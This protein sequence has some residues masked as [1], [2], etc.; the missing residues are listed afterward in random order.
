MHKLCG[1]MGEWRRWILHLTSKFLARITEIE[2]AIVRAFGAGS[3]RGR[4][5][6]WSDRKCCARWVVCVE[7]AE[8]CSWLRLSRKRHC[9]EGRTGAGSQPQTAHNWGPGMERERAP[10]GTLWVPVCVRHLHTAVLWGDPELTLLQ[11]MM[12]VCTLCCEVCI[13]YVCGMWCELCM[14]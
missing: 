3:Q 7:P 12:C 9:R 2:G 1:Q 10:V 5:H 6:R 13:W 4:G 11:S 8:R 14:C